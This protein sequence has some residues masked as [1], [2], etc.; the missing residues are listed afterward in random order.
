MGKELKRMRYFDGLLLDESDYTLDQEYQRKI[1]QLHNCYMHTNGII[2][3]LEVTPSIVEQNSTSTLSEVECKV[4]TEESEK[5]YYVPE[6]LSD[7]ERCEVIVSEGLALDLLKSEENENNESI[8]RLISIC[9]EHP[10]RKIDLSVHP[11]NKDIYIYVYYLEK[12]GEK[13]EDKR[14]IKGQEQVI[15]TLEVGGISHDVNRPKDEDKNVIIGRAVLGLAKETKT[16]ITIPNKEPQTTSKITNEACTATTIVET[17]HKEFDKET[18]ALKLIIDTNS[19]DK[20]TGKKTVT[21][22]EISK[23]NNKETGGIQITKT[24]TNEKEKKEVTTTTTTVENDDNKKEITIVTNGTTTDTTKNKIIWKKDETVVEIINKDNEELC[25]KTVDST[26]EEGN[27]KTTTHLTSERIPDETTNKTKI[28]TK[29]TTT[30]TNIVEIKDDTTGAIIET[31]EIITETNIDNTTTEVD[32]GIDGQIKTITEGIN[33]V[34]T[35]VKSNN[36]DTNQSEPEIQIIDIRI[37]ETTI[38]DED[39]T[40][41]TTVTTEDTEEMTKTTKVIKTIFRK[42]DEE[43]GIATTTTTVESTGKIEYK[44]IDK[45]NGTIEIDENKAKIIEYTK[46]TI[47]E[48]EAINDLEAEITSTTEINPV[49][50]IKEIS[51]F[52]SNGNALRKYSGPRG[53]ELTIGKMTFKANNQTSK[54]PFI[55]TCEEDN[56]VGLEF[57]S[58]NTNFTG[59]ITVKGDLI[60]KGQLHDNG[61]EFGENEMSISNSYVQVNSK[62][63]DWKLRDGGLQVY[64]GETEKS[65]DAC[66]R[67]SEERKKWQVGFMYK[68]KDKDIDKEFYDIAYGDKWEKLINRS[69][70]D[71]LHKHSKLYDS[72]NDAVLEIMDSGDLLVNRNFSLNDKTIWLRAN[73]NTNHGLGWYGKGKAFADIQ[74][75]GPVLFGL[76]GGILGTTENGQKAVITWNSAGNVGIGV[77]SPIDDRLELGGTLRILS[78]TNPIRFTSNWTG[79]NDSYIKNAEI[80]NDTSNA[81]AL[82]IVGNSSAGLKDS[83]KPIRKVAIWDRLDVNGVLYVKGD[84]QVEKAIRPS[85]GSG[86]N[87]IMFPKDSKGNT[88]WL[89]YYARS[90]EACTLEIGNYGTKANISLMASGNVGIGTNDPLDKLDVSGSMRLLSGTNPIR[91]TSSWD[92][93]SGMVNNQAEICNDTSRYKS[94]ILI[95]NKSSGRRKVSVWDDLDVNGSLTL[96]GDLKTQCAIT[97]SAGKGENNG[98]TFPKEY[99]GD[100]GDSAWIKYYSDEMRGGKENMTLEIGIGDDAGDGRYNGAG[101]RI[102]LYA[103][104]GVYVDGYFYYSSSRE[105]KENIKTLSTEKAKSILNGL[106]PVSFNFIGDNQKTTLGFIAE[107]VPEEVAAIDQKAISPMEIVAVL[108]SVVKEQRKLI[109]ELQQQVESLS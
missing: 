30:V 3:G 98:I 6:E 23:K 41:I 29:G 7:L 83:G 70:V 31:K 105:L 17:T 4:V 25:T 73:G 37:E 51:C 102:R 58:P 100:K 68:E 44:V 9:D 12:D 107:E 94:L 109:D 97:P 63:G 40:I 8:S 96:N 43:V 108:T 1:M 52:D 67:W 35:T 53:S 85:S 50:Y 16:T 71:D 34:T 99:N 19:T 24:I 61:N 64:R 39:K 72:S 26:I 60:V 101:D 91:F 80:S 76:N 92:G 33:T 2:T 21:N 87:G 11:A 32:S 82:V 55:R 74:V 47:T 69:I 104:G 75:D 22:T 77:K 27:I 62:S 65:P 86:T 13:E 45:A 90:G 81:K 28:Q 18:D 20:N 88:A 15:H 106:N 56:K 89:K 66:L 48:K 46:E 84:V 78:D 38:Q 36:E 57:D 59:S 79:I 103:S 14:L 5:K 95:G 42:E 54:M 93:T 10:D 49:K